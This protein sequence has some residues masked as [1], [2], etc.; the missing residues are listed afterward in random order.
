M[1]SFAPLRENGP[2]LPASRPVSISIPRIN[3]DSSLLHL[4]LNG[5]GTVQVPPLDDPNSK[6]G[7]YTGSPTPGAEGPAVILGHVDS[8]RYGPGV[9]YSLGALT[10][11]DTVDVARADR[12]T[13]RFRVDAVRRYTKDAFPTQEVYRNIDHA[14]LRLITCGGTFDAARGSYESSIIVFASLVSSRRG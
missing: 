12:S 6:A 3:V 14:G 7:W 2:V 13:A 5:D 9:F 1:P 10:P 11:G 8:A 4:G